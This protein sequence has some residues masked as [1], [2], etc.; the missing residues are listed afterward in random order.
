MK[1]ISIS[2]LD[3]SGKSTQIKLLQNYLESQG[4]RIFYFHSI[5]FGIASKI[6]SLFRKNKNSFHKKSVTQAS[7]FQI[8]LRKVCLKIDVLRFKSLVQKLEKEGYDYILSDRYFYDMI[9]NIEY[10]SKKNFSAKIPR[11]NLAFFLNADPEMIMKRE[12]PPEQGLEYL[13]EK[14]KLFK[15]KITQ[16]DLKVEDGNDMKEKVFESLKSAIAILDEKLI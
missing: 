1:I 3:G 12:N 10:L 11:P 7:T 2:G 5:E 13:I 4:K 16:W 9:V 8:W 15:D 6:N 14:N